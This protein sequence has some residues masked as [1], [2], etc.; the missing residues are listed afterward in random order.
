M[1]TRTKSVRRSAG[2]PSP[3]PPR[4][5]AAAAAAAAPCQLRETLSPRLLRSSAPHIPCP[6]LPATSET[7]TSPARRDAAAHFLPR[8]QEQ[9]CP[10]PKKVLFHQW[11]PVN[12]GSLAFSLAQ[13]LPAQP[14][15]RRHQ[16][17]SQWRSSFAAAPCL[18]AVVARC[19]SQGQPP[20]HARVS[21][22]DTNTM[23]QRQQQQLCHPT[24]R[25]LL[26]TTV[27]G[28]GWSW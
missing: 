1:H 2:S 3:P 28:G 9:A 25:N 21:G 10:R 13:Q 11:S 15:A 19:C 27:R 14:C 24:A 8:D 18:H 23:G 12:K 22:P 17:P 7:T 6:K 5:A 4:C 16:C 20:L 26:P